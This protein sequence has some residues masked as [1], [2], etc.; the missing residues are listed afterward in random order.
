MTMRFLGFST[1]D[2]VKFMSSIIRIPSAFKGRFGDSRSGSV[3]PVPASS[4]AQKSRP[5]RLHHFFE[6]TCERTPD[7]LAIDFVETGEQLTYAQLDARSVELARH[8][9]GLGIGPNHRV[10]LHL[11]RGVEPYIAMLGVLRAGAAYVPIEVETPEERARFTVEDSGA[12]LVITTADLAAR[13]EAT[14]S[15][16]LLLADLGDEY[17]DTVLPRTEPEDLCYLIYTSGTTGKPKGVCISHQN[18][19]TFVRGLLEVYG[20]RSTDRVLQGFSTAFDASVE[21]IWMAFATGATLVVGTQQTMRAVDELPEKLRMLGITVFSTVPTLLGVLDA[22]DQP[23]LRLLILGGEA[24]RGDIITKWS[25]PGRRLLNTYGPTETTVV[26]TYAWCAP[27]SPV[28]IGKPLPGYEAIVVDENLQPVPDGGEGELCVGGPAVS[29]HGYL[30]RADLNAQKFITHQ[31]RRFY[32]TGDLVCRDS[33]GDLLFRGRIDAQVKLRGYRV[34]LE[35][36]ESHIIREIDKLPES[37]AFQGVVVGVQEE[38]GSPQL[39][40]YLVQRRPASLGVAAVVD[41]LRKTLPPYMV[42]THFV[43]L[44]P[45]AVPRLASGKVDR[46]RLPGLGACRSLDTGRPAATRR[47]QGRD[48]VE[49]GILDVF[50]AVLRLDGAGREESFFDLGGNSMLAAEAVSRFRRIPEFTTLTIRDLYENSTAAT[51]AARLRSRATVH[52]NVSH[53]GPCS[54]PTQ[55]HRASRQ[56]FLAVATAQT[57][58]IF[59]VLSIGGFVGYGTLYGLYRLHLVLSAATP[60]WFWL[61]AGGAILLTPV[62]FM[63]TLVVGVFLKRILIG[64]TREGDHPVW[65]WGYFRW[66]AVKFLT[67]PLH[68]IAGSFVGTPLAPFFYR[69]MGARIGKGVSLGAPLQDPDLV[70]IE[71]GASISQE[72]SLGTHGLESGML[73]LRRVHVGRNAF[74]GAQAIVCGGA[75]LGEGAKLHPLSN[76]L[77]GT[78][79][80]PGT[81]WRGS[82]ATPV[83]PGTTELSRLLRRHEQEARPEDT[84]RSVGDT[85]RYLLLQHLYGYALTLIFL[86]PFVLEVA[87]LYAFGVRLNSAASFNLALLIPGAFLFAAVRFFSGLASILAA[88]W[89]LTGRARPGT[90]PLNGREYIRRQFCNQL[91]AM[92]TDLRG[93]YRPIT[94]TLLMPIY[95]RWLGMK[96]GRGAE[97]SDAAGYQPDLVSLGEGAML[98]DGCILGLPIV[99][100]GRMTL[101]HVHVG[102]RSFI[103]NGAQLPI[104]TPRLGDNSLVGVLSLAPDQPPPASNWLGSPPLRLPRREHWSAPEAL[105]FNPPRG[106]IIAR[107]LCNVVKMVLPGALLEIVFWV[108]FKLGLLA[109]LALGPVGCLPVIPLLVLGAALATLALPVILKWVLLGRYHSGQR[110]FWS[111]WMWRMETV[112]E[113]ELLVLSYYGG[114]LNGTPWLPLFYRL[115]GA[116]IGKQ[117]CIHG[118]YVLES[119]LTTIGDHVTLQGVLQTHLF[120]DRVMKLGTVQLAE[121]ASIGSES[122]VLYDSCVGIDTSLGD[123]S[124]VMKNETLLPGRRYRGLPAENV[125]EPQQALGHEAIHDRVAV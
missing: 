36:I 104:T 58:V 122:F 59:A 62:M 97:I 91:V 38:G 24:A 1:T 93:G 103:G 26:S 48:A 19:V 102:D 61:M 57:L 51:L 14:G 49:Q 25:A 63:T 95:C 7:A 98:A 81:E 46:K 29:I 86:V 100:R 71:D 45:T 21:E 87:L 66:W 101:G 115:Q 83:E 30:H 39:V 28:T 94:E 22:K 79:A 16:C 111:F 106:L 27:D 3:V 67:A 120:E 54:A 96:V 12:K 52:T 6:R 34:E 44:E 20:V 65:S 33:N 4:K 64:R 40:A 9:V 112:Y 42:P 23:Q 68:A 41:S 109:F 80:P 77:E 50:Q 125:V 10:A 99:H 72:A 82:P 18:A 108:T 73:S 117:V 124:L 47:D 110:Y 78:V 5:L 116:R 121:G 70:T 74:V 55:P 84:W 60:Y 90:I 118:G 35:E 105:T 107:A 32:R 2:E 11:P 31:G 89:L 13:F 17:E 85:L 75:S 76:L 119:D 15:Q 114:L 123:L 56:Q 37:G 43:A 69:L 88:K 92:I 8:L 53:S 113:V